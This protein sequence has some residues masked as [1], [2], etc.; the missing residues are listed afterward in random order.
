[1]IAEQSD[2]LTMPVLAVEI[3][4][5]ISKAS[6]ASLA[7]E[8]RVSDPSSNNTIR[9]GTEASSLNDAPGLGSL[10][11]EVREEVVEVASKKEKRVKLDLGE[12]S[13]RV[14]R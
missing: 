8:T 2:T 11:R 14:E 9:P 12:E 1:M 10:E 6:S 5:I 4:A 3:S 7:A 13:G